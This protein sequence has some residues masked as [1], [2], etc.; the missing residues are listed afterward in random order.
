MWLPWEYG[1]ALAVSFAVVSW[2]ARPIEDRVAAVSGEAAIVAVL[3]SLWQL[4]GRV[5]LLGIDAALER[6][7]W[8]WDLAQAL[9]SPLL[10][11]LERTLRLPNELEWQNALVPHSFW[12]QAANIYYAGAHVPAMGIFLV[13]LFFRHRDTYSG[14]RNTLALVT[15]M[16]LV[17]QLLPVAPPRLTDETGMIDTG[18]A[19]GQSVYGALGR[20]I[21]GQ[22]QAMPS[23]HVAWAALIGWAGWAE[24]TGRWRFVGPLHFLLTFVVVAVTGNHYWL[25]GIVAMVLLGLAR[26]VGL[27]IAR[28]TSLR[29]FFSGRTTMMTASTSRPNN[30]AASLS[31]ETVSRTPA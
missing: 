11:D 17:I 16:C 27:R 15:G 7:A 9:Q 25:D 28:V 12:T 5:S 22:L 23:I 19:Y 26:P 18:L 24:S 20:G 4:A 13:W 6:G 21:A 31:P 30:S 2:R 14:W 29:R 1:F 8:L 10:Q 3:Y